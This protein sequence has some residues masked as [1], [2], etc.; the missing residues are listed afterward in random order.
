MEQPNTPLPL[1]WTTAQ[2]ILFRFFFTYFLL[3]IFFNPNGVVPGSDAAFEYYIQPFHRLIPWIGQHILHLSKKITVFTNG[4][5]DTTYDNI[6]LLFLTLLAILTCLVWTLL[7]RKRRSYNIL[8]YWL[9]TII[10]YYLMMNDTLTAYSLRID[11]TQR[12]LMIGDFRDS[13]KKWRLRYRPAVKDSLVLWGSRFRGKQ[14]D[15]VS[16]VM[17][18]YPAERFWLT[19]RGFN[20]INEYPYNR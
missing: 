18:R 13:T 14:A 3:Y 1:Q 10:R 20:W 15:S 19:S 7:D 9:T 4:S 2:R 11:T 8:F 6:V 12:L 17:V 16:M 5:G